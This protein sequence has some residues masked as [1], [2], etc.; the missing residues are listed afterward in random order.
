[1]EVARLVGWEVSARPGLRRCL[2]RQGRV[3]QDS[4]DGYKRVAML[5]L[6]AVVLQAASGGAT[7]GIGDC[8]QGRGWVLPASSDGAIT[9][10]NNA[11]SGIRQHFLCWAAVLLAGARRGLHCYDPEQGTRACMGSGA[12]KA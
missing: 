4:S 11:T 1:M 6:A 2:H 9:V 5:S 8:Y 3:L 10:D 12:A 7:Y